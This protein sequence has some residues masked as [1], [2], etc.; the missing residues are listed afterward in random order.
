MLLT[1]EV[2]DFHRTYHALLGRPC[3]TKFMAVLNYTYLKLKV[4]SPNGV[5]TV[6]ASFQQ[7]YYCDQDCI[8]LVTAISVSGGMMSSNR[9]AEEALRGEKVKASTS[10]DRPGIAKV[11][12]ASHGSK[13]LAGPS[14]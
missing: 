11:P 14:I 4:P 13:G 3:F 5:I 7:T 12:N 9:S 2:V 6:S 10:L 8:A 1:Y